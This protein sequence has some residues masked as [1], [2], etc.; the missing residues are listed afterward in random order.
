MSMVCAGCSFPISEEEEGAQHIHHDTVS[1]SAPLAGDSIEEAM[2]NY[3]EHE[4]TCEKQ[5]YFHE[6]HCTKCSRQYSAV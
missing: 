3:L 5:L 2:E 4:L 6:E 1:C